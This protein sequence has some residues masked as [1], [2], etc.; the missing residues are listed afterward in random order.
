MPLYGYLYG[1]FFTQFIQ[2]PQDLG[3]VR[4]FECLGACGFATPILIND[5]FIENVTPD[6]VAEIVRRYL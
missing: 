3:V 1:Y 2:Q 5:D 4:S 6:N